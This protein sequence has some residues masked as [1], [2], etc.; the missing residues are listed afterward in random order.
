MLK[1]SII[2]ITKDNDIG[3]LKT[4]LSIK[5]LFCLSDNYNFEWVIKSG[6]SVVSDQQKRILSDPVLGHKIIYDNS[7]DSGIYD[8]MTRASIRSTGDLICYMN[9]GD[10]LIV[11]NFL[12][13]I[14][15][16]DDAKTDRKKS[17]V[18]GR[19]KWDRRMKSISRYL[20][21]IYPILGIL[22]SHQAI[23]FSRELQIQYEFDPYLK[24]YADMEWKIR[25]LR[26]GIF[27]HRFNKPICI[28]EVG[29]ISQV[30]RNLQ[31]LNQ[32]AEEVKYIMEKHY[33]IIWACIYKI[34]FYLWNLR[35]VMFKGGL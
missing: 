10:V 14:Q 13:M 31:D 8:A 29:G 32:K 28:G 2:T 11:Q 18:F 12:Q 6:D 22:P 21:G 25:L 20:S 1:I 3:L 30:M 4:Y 26:S 33:N 7:K 23:L 17:I 16:F 27:F 5:E 9:A 35:K 34:I 15:Y 24:Y 19:A